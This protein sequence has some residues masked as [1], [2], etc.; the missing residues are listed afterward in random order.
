MRN[1]LFRSVSDTYSQNNL[2][3]PSFI[4]SSLSTFFS[5]ISLCVTVSLCF[6]SAAVTNHTSHSSCTPIYASDHPAHT[7]AEVS[8]QHAEW[9]GRMATRPVELIIRI[10][11][12][13]A[14]GMEAA[15]YSSK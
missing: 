15:K 11:F 14:S 10:S 9:R 3:F 13:R 1:V 8:G 7:R 5:S 2:Y 4:S 12:N 6:G